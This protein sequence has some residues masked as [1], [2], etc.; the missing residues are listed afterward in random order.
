MTNETVPT[1]FCTDAS[2]N[3]LIEVK[4][5]GVALITIHNDGTITAA[6]HLKPTETAAE[7]LRIMR[8]TWMADAQSIKIRE[9]RERIKR[10]EEVGD[11]AQSQGGQAV[12][13]EERILFLAE[14]P[15]CNHPRELRAIAFQVRK[16][17][18]RIKQLESEND[19]LRADLLLWE[20]KEA[21]P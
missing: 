9:L 21:K 13:V 17:E 8:E 18:D 1:K 15:D 20:N 3:H 5:N 16:L 10:L 12:S 2:F 14:S 11:V 6:E 7:V 4:N 19:A